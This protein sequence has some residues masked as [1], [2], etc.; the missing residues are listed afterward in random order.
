MHRTR[1]FKSLSRRLILDLKNTVLD[2]KNTVLDTKN[3]VLDTKNT[4]LDTKNKV[5]DTKN[6]VFSRSFQLVLL[7]FRNHM[8]MGLQVLVFLV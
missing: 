4:V 8:I 6:K 2:L 3:T 1:E 7:F 5:L